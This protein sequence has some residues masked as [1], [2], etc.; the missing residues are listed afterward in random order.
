MKT[1]EQVKHSLPQEEL[2]TKLAG[3]QCM[4]ITALDDRDKFWNFF[5]GK[6]CYAAAVNTFITVLKYANKW[7]RAYKSRQRRGWSQQLN[8]RS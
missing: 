7:M 1:V 4:M 8:L 5:F 2:N 3:L 6:P